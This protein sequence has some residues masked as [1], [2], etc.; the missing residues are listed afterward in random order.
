MLI[1]DSQA[2]RWSSWVSRITGKMKKANKG[3]EGQTKARESTILKFYHLFMLIGLLGVTNSHV[4]LFLSFKAKKVKKA[5]PTNSGL[6]GF[7]NLE[8]QK[9]GNHAIKDS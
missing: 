4:S 1:F 5:A 8:I 7:N 2:Y 3:R 9:Y 6:F